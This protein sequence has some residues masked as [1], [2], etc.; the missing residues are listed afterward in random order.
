MFESIEDEMRKDE[1]VEPLGRRVIRYVIV[2]VATVAIL[3]GAYLA[4]AYLG[5]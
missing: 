5:G 1:G 2:A 4:I 3:G